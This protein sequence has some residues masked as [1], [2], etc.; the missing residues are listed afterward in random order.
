[1]FF[2][3][4]LNFRGWSQL[5]NYFNS[6]I[7]P[8]YS[9]QCQFT[10]RMYRS[11]TKECAQVEHYT[12]MLKRGVGALSHVT[13]YGY[14]RVPMCVHYDSLSLN[15]SLCWSQQQNLW[16]KQQSCQPLKL[17]SL[18]AHNTSLAEWQ[19]PTSH[20]KHGI[21]GESGCI[22]QLLLSV[23]SHLVITN[24]TEVFL[25][26]I[27]TVLEAVILKT[28]LV[29]ALHYNGCSLVNFDSIQKIW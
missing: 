10:Q 20:Y 7:F 24:D 6:K 23:Q 15:P 2:A 26:Q 12:Y 16:M 9:I 25:P 3:R 11:V 19:H 8:I 21:A 17:N 22:T 27:R 1:M 4:V 5:R 13:G 18:T 29:S 14:E 28:L